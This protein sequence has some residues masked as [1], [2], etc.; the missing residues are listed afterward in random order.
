MKAPEQA[1]IWNPKLHFETQ[2][3]KMNLSA[4][5][6]ETSDDYKFKSNAEK[7]GDDYLIQPE[8]PD[9]FSVVRVY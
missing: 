8:K 1:R 3:H 2:D 7:A 9:W 4:S 6:A 5:R